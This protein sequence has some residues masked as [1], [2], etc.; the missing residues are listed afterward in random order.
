M[1]DPVSDRRPQEVEEAPP[2]PSHRMPE[3]SFLFERGVP[4]IL[5]V[6]GIGTVI[7][8]SAALI[9]VLTTGV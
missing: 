3:G 9:V 8:I 2:T 6:L 7:L 4:I 1:H 5:I